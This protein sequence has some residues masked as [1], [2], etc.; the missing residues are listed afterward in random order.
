MGFT[1][2]MFLFEKLTGR[3][4]GG[5][6]VGLAALF[7]AAPGLAFAQASGEPSVQTYVNQAV[8]A[9][10][11][12]SVMPD[13]VEWNKPL[14]AG[15]MVLPRKTKTKESQQDTGLKAPD[16]PVGNLKAPQLKAGAKPPQL[17]SEKESAA[18]LM[19]MQGMKNALQ[20]SGV[21]PNLPVDTGTPATDSA[22]AETG[23]PLS[24][25]KTSESTKTEESLTYEPGR[26][27]RNLATGETKTGGGLFDSLST[28]EPKATELA[29]PPV[30]LETAGDKTP[31]VIGGAETLKPK[32]S[33]SSIFGPSVGAS[34]EDKT[35]AGSGCESK[36]LPWTRDC[37]EVGYPANYVGQVTGETRIQCPSGEKQDTWLSNS[38]GPSTVK[39][40][41][42]QGK[43]LTVPPPVEPA[44]SMAT[45][46][47]TLAN[48]PVS[49]ATPAPAV[50]SDVRVDANCGVANGSATASKPLADLCS[51]GSASDVSG[52]GPWRWTCQGLNGGMTV[53]CAAPVAQVSPAAKPDSG[54][55]G[56]PEIVK[57]VVAEDGKCGTA[58]GLG[59]D[60][61]PVADL[62]DKGIPSRVNGGGPWT[63]ACSGTGGGQAAAC[64]APR[65]INGACGAAAENGSEGM[66][67]RDLCTAG[68]ASAVTGT[69]P[70]NWTCS[71]LYGGAASTCSAT[72]KVNAVCGQASV[73]GHREPPVADLC[74]S[75]EASNVEGTGPWSWTCAGTHGGADVSCKASRLVDGVCGDSNGS[76]FAKAPDDGLCA[77]GRASRVTGR[78]PWS[79]NCAGIEG[80]DTA[81]CTALMSGKESKPGAPAACG[82]AAEAVLFTMPLDN[83]CSGG[84]PSAVSG[85]GPWTWSCSDESGNNVACT[86]LMAVEGA[87]GTAA[88]VPAAMAP[89]TDLCASGTPGKVSANKAK[90]HWTWNCRGSKDDVTVSCSAPA[91][92]TAS[93]Q[94]AESADVR[95]GSASGRGAVEAPD[96]GL[97]DAGKASSVKGKGPWTWSCS[98]G[99]NRKVSC[100]APKLSDGVCGTANGSIQKARPLT[101]LCAA[102]TPTDVDGEGP[103]LWSCVGTGGGASVSCSAASQAMARIDGSCGAAA[104]AVMTRAPDVNLCDSGVPSTV[105]GE[106]PWTWTCSGLNGGIASTCTTSKVMPKA[107]PPPAQ[108]VNGNCGPANGVAAVE[109]PED[110]LCSA[111]TTTNVSGNGPWN[112][113]CLGANGGMTVSCTAPLMP[114]APIEGVCGAANGIST[115]T[116]PRSA[117]C[118]AGIT[119]AVS[120]KGPWTWSCSGTNGGGA[121]SCVAPLAGKE[122][123]SRPLPSTVSPSSGE[124][125]EAPAPRAA[126]A[127]LVTPRLPTGPLPPLE[128]GT[129]P[130]LKPSSPL[131]TARDASF[132]APS[133]VPD[134]PAGMD[135]MAPPPVR[136]TLKPSPA[137][138]GGSDGS[139]DKV[140]TTGRLI[141]DSDISSLSFDHGSDVIDDDAIE[142]LD[143]LAALL[144][145]HGDARITLNAYAGTRGDITP[146]EARRLSLARALAVRDYLTKKGIASGRID[147]RALGA[148]VPSG[149]MDRVDIKMN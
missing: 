21:N 78:G 95:C 96:S 31:V 23:E 15:D 137:L 35:A 55:A 66:P 7:A 118:A 20:Q 51:S 120:G 36:V 45:A 77:Q 90:T 46:G 101:G 79:W 25:S 92:K 54:K 71:G 99:K 38:C 141:L 39:T 58:D 139:K 119:S 148:N 114:P 117:L 14:K 144:A 60:A 1:L 97:C 63:W 121:V 81:T 113:N 83:L 4:L 76:A 65:K 30:S 133:S 130:Q 115:L 62:C 8:P 102:G 109:K 43:D 40:A 6:I 56:K 88:N 125:G 103:W 68:L 98:A 37:K 108:P 27:P 140:T 145:R 29:M 5:A 85:N 73:T 26:G 49:A 80:G 143:K 134:L 22:K 34:A 122:G 61:A 53:S 24:L 126:P 67:E 10:P 106:G 111:G 32:A 129:L 33:S 116:P 70:W 42:P 87:C 135:T 93:A 47:E 128:T 72:P 86:S 107:P 82:P 11:A 84:K 17:S 138:K 110:G 41:A 100:E 104:N 19:L 131:D 44:A 52:E 69:G 132:V 16:L 3:R 142:I 124:S 149:D 2:P 91:A 75:G 136:D 50:P 74:Q 127:G 89:A 48:T 12:D 94:E 147:V 105:Y 13:G 28:G 59:M 146:R 57:E 123:A 9:V 18:S 112:W 64:R